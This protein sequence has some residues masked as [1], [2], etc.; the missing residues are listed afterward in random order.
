MVPVTSTASVPCMCNHLSCVAARDG[1]G[2]NPGDAEPLG[3]HCPDWSRQASDQADDVTTS[4]QTLGSKHQSRIDAG[5][6]LKPKGVS[7]HKKNQTHKKT[8]KKKRHKLKHC[9]KDNCR[10]PD[11]A[12]A[13][14][15]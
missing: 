10:T 12:E 8:K 6:L 11:T 15:S 9:E 14:S 7:K 5:L 13:A 3:P 4:L 2:I 1:S